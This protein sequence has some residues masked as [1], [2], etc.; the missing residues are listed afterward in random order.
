MPSDIT[1]ERSAVWIK[2]HPAPSP[3]K[4]E[5]GHENRIAVLLIC[6]TAAASAAGLFIPGMYRDKPAFIL[7]W[8]GNDIITL[9]VVLP[10]FAAAAYFALKGSLT[11]LLLRTAA[12]AYLLYNYAFYLFGAAL[13][14]LFFVYTSILTLSIYG[15]VISV[16]S[17][18]IK[19]LGK[20]IPK[21]LPANLISAYLVLVGLI[22][23]L[24]ES[25]QVVNYYLT[26]EPPAAPSLIFALDLTL[27]VPN[28]ALAAY[29]LWRRTNWGFL[30]AFI[31]LFKCFAYGLVLILNTI[32]IGSSSGEYDALLPFYLTVAAGG[33]GGLWLL[34]KNRL[35]TKY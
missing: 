22:L 1:A 26:G 8:T 35:L 28:C 2:S 16:P 15:L 4:K 23:T 24:A 33:A 12:M 18:L 21:K 31:M 6:L 11:A 19:P 13:N 9:F 3:E 20:Y 34:L 25:S 32:L 27:I 14:P 5:K 29:L 10:V 17:L 30:L 7:A